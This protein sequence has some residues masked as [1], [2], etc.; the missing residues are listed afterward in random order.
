ML[1]SP[2]VVHIFFS[3]S[4]IR[5]K[6][7][8]SAIPNDTRHKGQSRGRQSPLMQQKFEFI[9]ETQVSSDLRG[10]QAFNKSS[11]GCLCVCSLVSFRRRT[12]RAII[13]TINLEPVTDATSSPVRDFCSLYPRDVLLLWELRLCRFCKCAYSIY[14]VRDIGSRIN[15]NWF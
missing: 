5:N 9:Y 7:S 1:N 11:G 2:H 3:L 15:F 12:S 10:L 13:S 8:S 4:F 6:H 14:R